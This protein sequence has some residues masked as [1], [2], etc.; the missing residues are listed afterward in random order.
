MILLLVSSCHFP[1][2]QCP[3]GLLWATPRWSRLK[4]QDV[5]AELEPDQVA[6]TS[7]SREGRRLQD[8]PPEPG[9]A[10]T[11]GCPAVQPRA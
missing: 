10:E 5:Q 3:R 1:L 8:G 6:R 9:P 2:P 11:C 7:R 4:P